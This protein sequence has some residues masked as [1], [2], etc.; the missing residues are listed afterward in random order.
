M[1]LPPNSRLRFSSRISKTSSPNSFGSRTPKALLA[2]SSRS[3]RSTMRERSGLFTPTKH[4]VLSLAVQA[5]DFTTRR[6]QSQFEILIRHIFYR[7]LHNEL[8]TSD[9][10]DETKRVMLI[11]CAIA[12]PGMLVALF[13]FP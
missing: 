3:R 9:D 8:L 5:E 12:I 1:L 2:N 6:E 4:P 13:L 7:F 11:S 10:D